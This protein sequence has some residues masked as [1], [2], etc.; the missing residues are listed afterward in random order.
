MRRPGRLLVWAAALF[1]V[2]LLIVPTL[3]VIPVSL[4]D[5]ASFRFPPSGWSLR[6]YR[7]LVEEP[8]WRT[9]FGNSLLIATLSALTASVVGTAA[10]LGLRRFLRSIN[11]EVVRSTLLIPLIVPEIVLAVGLYS[12]FL[13][14]GLV[15]TLTGFVLAHATLGIPL[16]VTTVTA[17]LAGFDPNLERAAASLG[18]G[19]WMTARRVT[20]P[21]IL[22]GLLAGTLFAFILSLDNLVMSLFI[23]TPDLS[24]LP[25]LMW[26]SM[27]RDTDPTIA[28]AATVILL[29]T[30]V[31]LC[32]AL[33]ILG[34]R[35]TTE[36]GPLL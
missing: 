8:A 3:I 19:P 17:S 18:A 25:V 6:W 16:V 11:R 23:Q 28:A 27:T 10:A 33:T 32:A 9:T 1:A 21:L 4:G 7:Q 14:I 20:V 15:G 2:L 5:Q 29:T 24:T 30:T 34:R 13:K 12:F 22:P 36:R 35:T 26:S 31:V